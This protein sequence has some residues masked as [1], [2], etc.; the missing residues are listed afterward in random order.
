MEFLEFSEGSYFSCGGVRGKDGRRLLGRRA[1]DART[2]FKYF[3]KTKMSTLIK[4]V[5]ILLCYSFSA[6]ILLYFFKSPGRKYL[7]NELRA[8]MNDLR[9]A[10]EYIK[11]YT[12]SS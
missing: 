7:K 4:I 6:R 12:K 2:D 10:V 8:V 9:E 1:L 11:I 5:A 3:H